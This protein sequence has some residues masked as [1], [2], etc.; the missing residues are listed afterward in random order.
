MFPVFPIPTDRS[1]S[2]MPQFHQEQQQQQAA[3][4]PESSNGKGRMD[5]PVF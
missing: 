1:V 3:Y 2:I 4:W 5:Q